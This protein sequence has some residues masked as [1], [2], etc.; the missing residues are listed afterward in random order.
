MR[1]PWRCWGKQTRY[2]KEKH[3]KY[4]AENTKDLRSQSVEASGEQ[5]NCRKRPCAVAHVTLG[6]RILEL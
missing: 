5:R 6:V 3:S 1:R 4:I 2:N